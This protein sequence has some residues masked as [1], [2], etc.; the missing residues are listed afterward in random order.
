MLHLLSSEFKSSPPCSSGCREGKRKEKENKRRILG[1]KVSIKEKEVQ[2]GIRNTLYPS[3]AQG[4]PNHQIP[5][6]SQK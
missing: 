2:K 4:E 3:F 1:R 5:F 6:G